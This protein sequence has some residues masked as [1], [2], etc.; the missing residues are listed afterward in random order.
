V[1]SRS[2]KTSF[3]SK[4][5]VLV[6]EFLFTPRG[7]IPKFPAPLRREF[8]CKSMHSLAECRRNLANEP[9]N[10]KNSLQIPC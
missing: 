4:K 6:V 5:I 8:G 2:E 3:D 7:C 1:V 9:K 10:F